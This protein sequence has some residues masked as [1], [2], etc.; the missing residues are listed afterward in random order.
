MTYQYLA[1]SAI[2]S[3]P[4]W[5]YCTLIEKLAR[6]MEC[7]WGVLFFK[8]ENILLQFTFDPGLMITDF[9]TTQPSMRE[10]SANERY[11]NTV[12]HLLS[13]TVNQKDEKLHTARLDDTEI[14]HVKIKITEILHEKSSVSQ[15]HRAPL[16]KWKGWFISI[17]WSG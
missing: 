15:Y 8:Q 12:K 9:R 4:S 16:N 13:N 6:N 14:P 5:S 1:D 17:K 3:R 7:F 10:E 11:C 2:W